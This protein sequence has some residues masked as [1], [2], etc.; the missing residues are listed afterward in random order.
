MARLR[1]KA[2]IAVFLFTLFVFGTLMGLRTLKPTDDIS[3]LAPRLDILPLIGGKLD[4]RSVARHATPPAAPPGQAQA[5]N[6]GTNTKA[7]LSNSGP[8][9]TVFYDVHIFYNT[10]YGT[11]QMD[12]K[13]IHWDHILVPHW[14]PKI[15]AS[16]PRGR[17][18]PP[19]DIGSS[20]YP[21]LG[22]YSSRDPDVLES[23]MEQIGA[24]A[25]GTVQS[26]LGGVRG[27]THEWCLYL[28]SSCANVASISR[29]VPLFSL[30]GHKWFSAP[31]DEGTAPPNNPL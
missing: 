29:K 2:C 26:C 4:R 9:G 28:L 10:W 22:A 18:M 3:D 20:F 14:D 21:E 19:E 27:E 25:A 17:H 24:S 15:A 6:T 31:R 7:A 8:E 5:Q 1:R 12:G 13:Y 11:P 16:Y 23:H 30:N